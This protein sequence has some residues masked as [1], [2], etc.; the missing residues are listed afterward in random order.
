MDMY[1]LWNRCHVK[2]FVGSGMTSLN[3][4]IISKSSKKRFDIIPVAGTRKARQ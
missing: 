2:Y 3:D 4:H 1:S